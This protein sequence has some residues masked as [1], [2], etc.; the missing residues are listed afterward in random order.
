MALLWSEKY[1]LGTFSSGRPWYCTDHM[2]GEVAQ[3]LE[4]QKENAVSQSII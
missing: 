3:L 2:A 4:L 1:L